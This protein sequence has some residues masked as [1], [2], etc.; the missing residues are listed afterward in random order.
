MRDGQTELLKAF[1]GH[2]RSTDAKL[3]TVENADMRL[4][5]RFTAVE[6]RVTSE[7]VVVVAPQPSRR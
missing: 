2:A 6:Y 7:A 4:R 1:Y 5:E 3:K